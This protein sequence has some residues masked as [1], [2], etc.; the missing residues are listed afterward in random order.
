[1]KFSE[2]FTVSVDFHS[3]WIIG[4]GTGRHGG[5][6]SVVARDPRGLPLVRGT[7][8]KGVLR[9]QAQQLALILDSTP[10][11]VPGHGTW[12]G[13]VDQ[14][15]GSEPARS[16]GADTSSTRPRAGA[17][18]IADLHLAGRLRAAL[19]E[20]PPLSPDQPV[21]TAPHLWREELLRACFTVRPGVSVHRDLKSAVEN[22]NRFEERAVAGLRV[23][24]DWSWDGPAGTEVPP[25]WLA[26][27]EAAAHQSIRQGKKRTRGAGKCTVTLAY[28][29]R[30]GDRFA[31]LS[32][33]PPAA[34]PTVP[35]RQ[36]ATTAAPGRSR[37]GG[38]HLVHAYDLRLIAQEPVLVNGGSAFVPGAMLLGA[39]GAGLELALADL[40]RAGGLVV[41]DALIEI[42]CIRSLPWPG[43]LKISK[44]AAGQEREAVNVSLP[45]PAQQR[46]VA[47]SKKFVD[48]GCSTAEE[49]T[50]IL[51]DHAVIDD[52]RGQPTSEVGG[53]YSYQAIAPGTVLRAEV[54]L[55]EGMDLDPGRIGNQ[56]RLGSARKTGYGL[57]TIAL[58]KV[59]GPGDAHDSGTV[60]EPIP[61]GAVFPLW[62]TSAM[63]LR[64]GTGNYAPDAGLLA[65]GFGQA[66]GAAVTTVTAA[67]VQPGP[68]QEVTTN[69]QG[70]ARYDEAWV[71]S[72]GLP[73]PALIGLAPGT[74]IL[75]RTSQAISAEA[76]AQVE[77]EGLG[78]RR[79]EGFGRILVNPAPLQRD[80][81]TV[82]FP[83]QKTTDTIPGGP[84][85]SAGPESPAADTH[86][87]GLLESAWR[88][89]IEARAVQ[90]GSDPLIPK[91]FLPDGASASQ[92][93]ALRGIADSL[94]LEG[95]NPAGVRHWIEGLTTTGKRKLWNPETAGKLRA[96]LD[97][98]P[99]E[100][101]PLW[102]YYF[103][104][105][106][107]QIPAN[108]WGAR[109][110]THA[111]RLL[112]T[113]VVKGHTAA[114]RT[115]Q[116]Q[117]AA[118]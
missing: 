49:P 11:D 118:E 115:N 101:D 2:R 44:D 8:L 38:G 43:A 55:P 60:P 13:V 42:A 34:V 104:E 89:R 15:F 110:R 17:L 80:T 21:E 107:D 48:P 64:D 50:R 73:R 98:G 41:T 91:D 69:S 37:G 36:P 10:Q 105:R 108:G 81:I 75:V 76:L 45:H 84:K 88:R 5:I 74:V 63:L 14:I 12:L 65:E 95:G 70:T 87:Q 78:D 66:V 97:P 35:D 9:D 72:W 39:V 106:P 1:M 85:A 20:T 3:D 18:Q 29:D 62:C 109:L 112:L 7:G 68:G 96:V 111:L 40:I 93:G 59:T 57:C 19:D 79:A 94:T 28:P 26:L 33:P 90:L 25:A 24:A 103:G 58:T 113:E 61:A 71:N 77:A 67:E 30:N 47:A 27:L 54:W 102:A 31:A 83:D 46:L 92:A 52:D 99:G 116:R 114:T 22:S 16:A 56:L 23:Q 32:T 4:T 100:S 82:T 117:G 86:T 51:H 53:L 6:D